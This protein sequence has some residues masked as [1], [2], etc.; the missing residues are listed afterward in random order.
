MARSA[1]GLDRSTSVKETI[2]PPGLD[3]P[4]LHL[5]TLGVRCFI[6]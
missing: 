3:I 2:F 4:T 5:S 1:V 6:Q